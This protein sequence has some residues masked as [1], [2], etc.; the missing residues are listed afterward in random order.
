[1]SK[2][3]I[4][5]YYNKLD[6]YKRYGGTRNESSIRRAF[7]NLLEDYCISKKLI[8]VD[9]LQVKTLHGTSRRIPDGTIRDALQ[10][11]WRHWESKDEKDILDDE[12]D[13]K[14]AIG[15]PKY[16]ILFE[17]SKE[18][19]LIQKAK[20]VM[21]GSMQEADFFAQNFN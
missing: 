14:F 12:I 16:N 20:E 13:K 10:L 3:A 15:Y 5:N 2:Q 11:D 18:I 19:I 7:A 1:M 21:R 6:Q 8:L 9:E 17:N 4:T